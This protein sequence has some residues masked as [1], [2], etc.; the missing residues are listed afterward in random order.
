MHIEARTGSKVAVY[1]TKL[2]LRKL[3][4]ATGMVQ[5]SQL[6][7]H[8]STQRMHV[9]VTTALSQVSTCVKSN[10]LT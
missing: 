3:A 5:H 1:G 6:M 7:R 2:A 8:T 4:P 10:S 9:L